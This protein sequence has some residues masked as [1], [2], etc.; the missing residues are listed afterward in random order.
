V[1]RSAAT[2]SAARVVAVVAAALLVGGLLG[3]AWWWFRAAP[4]LARYLPKDTQVYVELPSVTKALVGLAGVDA[5]HE[6]DLDAEKQKKRVVEA[7]ADSFELGLGNVD[8]F[9]GGVR[10]AAVAGR[11]G[12]RTGRFDMR[13]EAVLLLSFTSEDDVERVLSSGRF[14][15][16]DRFKGFAQ[17]G[18]K[19][20]SLDNPDALAKQSPLERALDEIGE[21]KRPPEEDP[22]LESKPE[23]AVMWF[24]DD[25][26][27]AVGSRR[28]V[29]DC[30][31]VATGEHE[32]LQSGNALFD[33]AEW[34]LRS[35]VLAYVDPN[36][37]E[38]RELRESFLDDPDPVVGALRLLD[39]GVKLDLRFQLRGAKTPAP[40]L[41][42]VPTPLTL[43]E[44]LPSDTFAYL[45]LSTRFAGSGKQ[46]EAAFFDAAAS[47]D[48]SSERE[49]QRVV[50]K[51]HEETDI[52]LSDLVEISG[53]QA[54]IGV[55]ADDGDLKDMLGGSAGE[56]TIVGIVEVSDNKRAQGLV[57]DLRDYL[58]G[59]YD[60]SRKDGGFLG[61]RKGEPSV[62]VKLAGE[63]LLFAFGKN[64]SV[65]DFEDVYA[66]KGRALSKD[67][68]HENARKLLSGRPVAFMWV[69]AGRIADAAFSRKTGGEAATSPRAALRDL[70][71]PIDALDIEGPDRITAWAALFVSRSSGSVTV[72]LQSLNAVTLAGLWALAEAS[73][74]LGSSP[75]LAS[76]TGNKACDSYVAALRRCIDKSTG[77]QAA[78]LRS[79]LKSALDEYSLASD[80]SLLTT[81]CISAEK[82]I[83]TLF[84]CK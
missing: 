59:R 74:N 8:R 4:A 44:R 75:T 73:G 58:E 35:T 16:R 57:H 66:G 29:E 9:I 78:S 2:R 72:E 49:L 45:E 46:V 40:A 61:E 50:D 15:K 27:L 30:A 26:V 53:H 36:L 47:I 24:A 82:R 18:V 6:E 17:Y 65:E 38:S 21:P 81:E 69:D 5:V 54:V 37:M 80:R 77:A 51:L 3:A 28:M 22:E 12:P 7:F 14:E 42:P 34:P 10:A 52:E 19:R 11:T 43:H 84:S 25:K 83:T 41:F 31:R 79:I 62:M 32:S 20:R 76:E 60:V 67:S 70:D 71:I 55:V 63:H 68:A 48:A 1:S 56:L 64:G 39:E 33:R 13:P 23:I